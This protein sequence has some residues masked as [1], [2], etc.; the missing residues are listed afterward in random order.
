MGKWSA[1]S[2][3]FPALPGDPSRQDA[4]TAA[5]DALKDKSVAEL[6]E[7]Y[8][9]ADDRKKQIA[10]DEKAVNFDLEVFTRAFDAKLDAEDLESVVTNGYRY[11]PTP[12]PFAQVTDKVKF[13]EW[14][15]QE[16]RDNLNI[17]SGTLNAVVKA[18]LESGAE[19]PPGVDVYIKRGIHRTKQ[20]A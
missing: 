16:M 6:S 2:D 15:H 17:H 12:E 1:I 11:T 20:K 9:A 7:L 14:A 5:L 10:K 13:L 8:N 4:L 18:A 19:L 3:K